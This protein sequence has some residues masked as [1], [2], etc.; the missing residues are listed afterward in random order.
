MSHSGFRL[1]FVLPAATALASAA[2]A[3]TL[4]PLVTSR[5]DLSAQGFGGSV[6]VVN[7]HVLIGEASNAT[8]PGIVYV[9]GRIGGGWSETEDSA[10]R[11]STRRPTASGVPLTAMAI[12]PSSGR[13]PWK[14][15]G[16][17]RWSTGTRGRA[18]GANRSG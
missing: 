17:P 12:W 3:L 13:P 16:G 7:G 8:L 2:V 14:T 11:R 9:Y 1:P 18:I 4:A 5:L 6:A 15:D 10:C